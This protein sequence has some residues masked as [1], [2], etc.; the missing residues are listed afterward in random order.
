MRN[1]NNIDDFT[2]ELRDFILRHGYYVNNPSYSKT[3]FG[4][5]NYLN[6]YLTDSTADYSSQQK[7]RISDHSVQNYDR[8]FNEIHIKFPYY[9]SD[10]KFNDSDFLWLIRELNFKFKRNEY[11]ESRDAI[12]NYTSS[13]DI[14]EKELRPTDKIM[15][16]RL[17]S[18]RRGAGR[19]IY[20]IHRIG[21]KSII[22]WV[23]KLTGKVYTTME[24]KTASKGGLLVGESHKN[25]G[26]DIIVPEG[27]IEAEGNEIILTKGVYQSK[28]K[29]GDIVT[30]DMTKREA[31]SA[32]NESE[33]GIK[34]AEKGTLVDQ[35]NKDNYI[36]K[37]INSANNF[38]SK[39]NFISTFSFESKPAK[40]KKTYPP[41][42]YLDPNQLDPS[43]YDSWNEFK[44]E[45]N[46]KQKLHIEDIVKKIN[47]KEYI[48]P[49]LVERSNYRSFSVLDGHHRALAYQ[50]A[51]KD[52]PVY[53]TDKELAYI[54]EQEHRA[55]KGTKIENMQ[56]KIGDT[57]KIHESMP[58]M[59]SLSNVTGKDL[60]VVGIKPVYFASGTQNYLIVETYDGE[61]HEVPERF[62][63]PQAEH[64]AKISNMETLY[65]LKTGNL[66]KDEHGNAYVIVSHSK[67][68]IH[69]KRHDEFSGEY[70]EVFIKFSELISKLEGG[71]IKIL[72]CIYENDRDKL[73]FLKEVALIGMEHEIAEYGKKI[74]IMK[75]SHEDTM[76]GVEALGDGGKIKTHAQFKSLILETVGNNHY[77]RTPEADFKLTDSQL[78]EL[79]NY[80][81]EKDMN[82]YTAAKY[83]MSIN[84]SKYEKITAANGAR[85]KN[86][87]EGKTPER[88][89]NDWTQE[90]RVHF[91]VDHK[92]PVENEL[93]SWDDFSKNKNYVSK[94]AEHI[95]M[96]QYKE[97]GKTNEKS[98]TYVGKIKTKNLSSFP[99]GIFEVTTGATSN[100]EA[101]SELSSQYGIKN[102]IS[103]KV[104]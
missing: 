3:D 15:S 81:D 75:K 39:D 48:H 20:S 90:Q 51:K 55:E 61:R 85:I 31:A 65:Y 104:G 54:W 45:L 26:I 95:N 97:G 6:V 56:T 8:I 101:R 27:K 42:N 2:L 93:L 12:Q 88:L 9:K 28:E 16:T 67:D 25:G 33:G 92:I 44:N 57:V 18:G 100:K 11:F 76:G 5:S 87:Y 70:K 35:L 78:K 23:D 83:L 80:M 84:K 29:V 32:L 19:T 47:N 91:C 86:Q 63:N 22:E 38:I 30:S 40:I 59:A 77:L 64:G 71:K 58:Y 103:V 96:E 82:P 13:F 17:S 24:K 73:L 62:I 36:K 60:K 50:L 72:G 89:W 52:I 7:I 21:S 74:N 66:V 46:A 1:M 10:E 79:I 4:N 94:L 14:N 37:L 69:I 43:E 98:K 34:I 68:G 49:I 41:H 99:N 102:V 53:Y